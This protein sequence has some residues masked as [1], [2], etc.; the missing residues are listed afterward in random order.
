MRSREDCEW[1][2]SRGSLSFLYPED[3]TVVCTVGG[4]EWVSHIL[5]CTVAQEVAE[6]V[7]YP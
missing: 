7:V 2:R 1:C 3:S 5:P 4:W 6:G